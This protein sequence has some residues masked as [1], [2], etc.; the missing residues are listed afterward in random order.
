ML[1]NACTA[2][3]RP[4]GMSLKT[5]LGEGIGF[6]ESLTMHHGI[7]EQYF[8]P[9]LA[10]RMPEFNPRTGPLVTQHKEI[11]EGL[12]RFEAYLRDCVAGRTEFQMSG[13]RERMDPWGKV[14]WAHLDDEVKAL[15]AEN[16]R[17]YWSKDEIQRMR[18]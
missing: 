3:K 2:N 4:G 1:W 11:H 17:K 13:L 8:F 14:L 5:F 12:D 16:M 18:M 9:K 10:A 6:A 7:E 15:G